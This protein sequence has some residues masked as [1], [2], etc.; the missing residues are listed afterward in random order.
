MSPFKVIIAGG[1]PVG[2]TAAHALSQAGIDFLLLEGHHQVMA[3]VGSNL[4]LNPQGLRALSQLGLLDALCAVSDRLLPTRRID[5]NARDIGTM[6]IFPIIQQQFGLGSCVISRHDLLKVLY[7][8]LPADAR[9]KILTSKKVAT[10]TSLA[11]GVEVVCQDGTSYTGSIVIGADGVHSMVR[12]SMRQLALAAGSSELNDEKPYL[13]T[14]RCLWLRFPKSLVPELEPGYTAEAH[15][16]NASSQLFLG[17]ETGV[18]AIYERLAQPTSERLAR[19]ELDADAM[20]ARWEHMAL[21]P[22]GSLTMKRAYQNKIETGVVSLEE[23]V[24][25]HWSWNGRIALVG[26]AAHKYTPSTGAG[27]N[28]GIV[29]IVSLANELVAA[30]TNARNSADDL[31]ASPTQAA[32]AEAFDNYQ[33]ARYDNVVDGCNI[34]SRATALS[35]WGSGILKL[36][37]RYVMSIPAVQRKIMA[38]GAGSVAKMPVF[39]FIPAEERFVGTVAWQTPMPQHLAMA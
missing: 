25:Q 32:L 9:A 37:D 1:G 23:G 4:V 33:H 38:A 22:G 31:D 26:D 29:D 35:T 2:L 30:I 20:A 18:V 5:H 36:V 21:I 24:V 16:V 3:S 17:Q 14:Y 8:A 19:T 15:G 27:C 34:S 12:K 11:D 6:H 10:V 39:S 28:T 7:E 13:T